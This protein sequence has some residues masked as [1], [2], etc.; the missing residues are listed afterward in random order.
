MACGADTDAWRTCVP[1]MVLFEL[2]TS[3]RRFGSDDVVT[4]TRRQWSGG[5]H[6]G[7]DRGARVRPRTPSSAVTGLDKVRIVNCISMNIDHR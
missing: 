3:R 7:V 4:G 2:R 6:V 5:W 1:R